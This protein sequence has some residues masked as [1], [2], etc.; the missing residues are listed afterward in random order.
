MDQR[1][2]KRPP[3]GHEHGGLVGDPLSAGSR[4]PH[5]EERQQPQRD[6][7]GQ[8]GGEHELDRRL[9]T[10]VH[11]RT[12]G[13]DEDTCGAKPGTRLG[14][15]TVTT[16][17]PPASRTVAPGRIADGSAAMAAPAAGRPTR[18][19]RAPRLEADSAAV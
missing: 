9:P 3:L 13:A 14:T 16:M 2:R 10:D 15:C 17:R 19:A 5:L 6:R 12:T 7:A 18:A 11:W 8:A 4:L 1:L